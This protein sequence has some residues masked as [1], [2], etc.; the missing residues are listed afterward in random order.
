MASNRQVLG[1][2]G[3]VKYVR[4]SAE[5]D[6]DSRAAH[7]GV[8]DPRLY[9]VSFWN[10]DEPVALL[11]YYACHPQSF[12]GDRRV[13]CDFPGLARNAFSEEADVFQVHFCGAAGN[14]AAGK[15]NDGSEENRPVLADRVA[16]GMREA[17][18][19]TERTPVSASDVTWDVRRVALPPSDSLDEADLVASLREEPDQWTARRLAWLDRCDRGH[20][21]PVPCLHAGPASVLHAPGELF[22]E[23]QLAAREWRPDRLV[24]VAAYGDGGPAYIGTR[25]AYPMGGYEV[26]EPSL[27]SPDAEDAL[28]AAFRD[29]LDAPD[30]RG[31]TPSELTEGKPRLSE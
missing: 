12:Y 21:I 4:F 3:T 16:A 23:Y 18:E 14:V 30:D 13:T 27:V 5:S 19:A 20:R 9:A 31:V 24:T 10:A 6:S 25:A 8:V 28:V 11:T 26:G 15:Y 1:P 7:E 22:V 2:D 29:L 17:W